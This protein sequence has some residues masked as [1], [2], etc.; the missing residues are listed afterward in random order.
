MIWIDILDWPLME[1]LDA[2]W[3]DHNMPGASGQHQRAGRHRGRG[4]SRH[5]YGH[6]GIK[7]TFVDHQRGV[8]RG[9]RRCSI[10]AAKT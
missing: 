9:P 5:L 4:Y 6:G 10:I 8:G 2:A 1:F 3:V 7:P